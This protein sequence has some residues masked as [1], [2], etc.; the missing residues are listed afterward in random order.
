MGLREIYIR[1]AGCL[2]A[3]H[4]IRQ[5]LAK[6]TPEVTGNLYLR[7]PF[8]PVTQERTDTT[9]TVE[10][11]L[12]PELNGLYARIGPNPLKPP[13]KHEK[14]HW[15]TGDGMVHG[16]R[17]VLS[18]ESMTDDVRWY[19]VDPCFVFQTCNADDTPDGGVVMDVVVHRDMFNQ[20][21]VGPEADTQPRFERWTLPAQVPMGFHGSR[22][23]DSVLTP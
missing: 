2:Q 3:V 8:A 14:Y 10:G 7:E 16:V 21:R 20:S 5:P 22:I 9:L 12:P 6:T 4:R 19:D 23:P 1:Q 13:V 15:F 18:R 11:Q 17:L